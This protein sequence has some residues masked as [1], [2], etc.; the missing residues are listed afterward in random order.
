M[1]ELIVNHLLGNI[2]VWVFPFMAGGGV[3][4][5]IIAGIASHIPPVRIYALIARPV[6]FVVFVLGVFFYGGAGVIAVQQQALAEAKQKIALAEQAS[7]DASQRLA[8]A[9]AANEHLV[10]G[11]G[12]GV[13][14]IIVHDKQIID[15]DCARINDQ[16]WADY[17]RAVKN[18]GS[19]PAK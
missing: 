16:A 8:D 3:A 7:A 17:N 2:P 5:Y 15:K 19:A 6:A 4:T 13:K 12:Y 10:K 1:F 14:Q 18:T 9:L 11:R